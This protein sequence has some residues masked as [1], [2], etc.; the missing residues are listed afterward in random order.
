MDVERIA[1]IAGVLM[2]RPTPHI[3]ERGFFCRTFDAD[4]ARAAG[5]NPDA[6]AQDSVSRSAGG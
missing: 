6:F 1:E 3:D 2:F 4:V 5:I